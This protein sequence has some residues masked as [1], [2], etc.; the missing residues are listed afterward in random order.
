[1]RY[2]LILAAALPPLAAAASCGDDDGD[3]D[4]ADAGVDCQAYCQSYF[5]DDLEGCE[6]CGV[7][8]TPTEGGCACV[9]DSCVPDLC[10][11]WCEENGSPDGG[12]CI[13]TCECT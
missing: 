10:T 9:F 2:V 1:M 12:T 6:V 7:E 4:G 13:I 8:A 5:A 3:D 11:E